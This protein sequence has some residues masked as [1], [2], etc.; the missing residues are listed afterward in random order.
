MN[1]LR[2][3]VNHYSPLFICINSLFHRNSHGEYNNMASE[4]K[5]TNIESSFAMEDL[6]FDEEC[7]DR[8]K[9]IL[10]GT[11]SIQEAIAELNKKYQN[12]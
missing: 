4:R 1:F 2:R 11:L 5:L 12:K 10:E 6:P 7:R 8:I 3:A 9:K